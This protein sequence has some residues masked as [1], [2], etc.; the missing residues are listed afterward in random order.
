M[1][2]K[3]VSVV[4]EL[5]AKL[6]SQ[7]QNVYERQKKTKMVEL[8]GQLLG[9]SKPKSDSNERIISCQVYTFRLRVTF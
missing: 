8:I 5:Y 7:K 9:S 4:T 3:N 1:G 2:T 6:E